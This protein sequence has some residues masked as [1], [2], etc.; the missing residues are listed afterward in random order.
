MVIT[1]VDYV[2][3]FTGTLQCMLYYTQQGGCV[4]VALCGQARGHAFNSWQHFGGGEMQKFFCTYTKLHIKEPRMAKSNLVPT[5]IQ[6]PSYTTLKFWD[7]KPHNFN[8]VQQKSENV[9]KKGLEYGP[10]HKKHFH[11]G[12][13]EFINRC[14]RCL[15]F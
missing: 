12:L 7:V 1:R 5:T 10:C 13:F 6:H 9:P 8:A 14:C 4:T 2:C 3:H 11:G 15:F